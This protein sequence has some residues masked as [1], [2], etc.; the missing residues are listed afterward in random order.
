V[1]CCNGIPSLNVGR[2]RYVDQQLKLGDLRGN[3]FQ[4][5]LRNCQVSSSSTAEE[6]ASDELVEIISAS[7]E[8]LKQR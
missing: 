6:S 3:Q 4:I 7:L 5:V 2:C 8:G 1:Q